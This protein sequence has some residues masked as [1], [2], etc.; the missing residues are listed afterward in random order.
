[1]WSKKKVG[2]FLIC[3]ETTS[4]SV[5]TLLQSVIVVKKHEYL[6][7]NLEKY[8]L[9]KFDFKN[10]EQSLELINTQKYHTEMQHFYVAGPL[11]CLK[12]FVFWELFITVH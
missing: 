2:N 10:C 9:Y 7:S 1:L 11:P 6:K 3:W 4:V 5:S 8:M 12:I